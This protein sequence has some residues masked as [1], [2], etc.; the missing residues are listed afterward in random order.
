[1][2]QEIKEDETKIEKL[3]VNDFASEIGLEPNEQGRFT[4]GPEHNRL[5]L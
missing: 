1:M 3:S 2:P 4:F 5:A